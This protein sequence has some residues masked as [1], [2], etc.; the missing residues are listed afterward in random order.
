M[1]GFVNIQDIINNDNN[2]RQKIYQIQI[3]D[4]GAFIMHVGYSN[5]ISDIVASEYTFGGL[6]YHIIS[7]LFDNVNAT[8]LPIIG[9]LVMKGDDVIKHLQYNFIPI[10]EHIESSKSHKTLVK[11]KFTLTFHKE[12]KYTIL[13][14]YNKSYDIDTVIEEM[15]SEALN[16]D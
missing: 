6:K 12:E 9:L 2:D 1:S 14:E 15:I 13:K 3:H 10:G 8:S 7:C 5:C 11:G 16:I 4:D